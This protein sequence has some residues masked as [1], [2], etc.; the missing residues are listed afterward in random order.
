M[1]SRYV[2]KYNIGGVIARRYFY[3]SSRKN[4]WEKGKAII[5]PEEDIV[6]VL[7]YDTNVVGQGRAQRLFHN[8]VNN[9]YQN[10]E[11]QHN[12]RIKL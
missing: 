3:A 1:L 10:I 11:E 4:S 2:I 9:A 6:D 8:T 7:V 12:T 5:F